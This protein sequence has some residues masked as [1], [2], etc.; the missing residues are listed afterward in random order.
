MRRL[1]PLSLFL[2]PLASSCGRAPQP[3]GVIRVAQETDPSTLDP[4]RSYDS[5]SIIYTR[6]LYRGLVDYGFDA[7]I[8]DE[9]AQNHTISPDGK[10]YRFQLRPDVRWWDG[11][12][13]EAEDFRYSIE[14]ALD[15][16]TASDGSSFF[17]DIVGAQEWVNSLKTKN[18]LRH[19]KGLEVPSPRELVIH[20]SKPDSTFLARLTLPFAYAVPHDYVEGLRKQYGGGR[21]L[22]DALSEHPMGC[23]PFKFVEWVHDSSLRLEKNPNYFRPDLPKANV[24]QLQ[25]GIG[26]TL[27]TMLFEQGALDTLSITDAFPADFLR[28]K[29][30]PKWKAFIDDAPLMDIRYMAMNTE[31]EPFKD[32]RVR[33]AVSYAINYDRIVALRTGRATKARGALPEGVE[34]YDPKLFTY[35]YDPAKAKQLLKE[36][37]FKPSGPLPLIYSTSEQWYAKAAQSIQQDLATVGIQVQ[38][39]GMPYGDLKAIAAR[40]GPSGGRFVIQGW[41][42]DFPDPSNYLDPLFN[43]RSIADNGSLNRSFYSNPKVNE[44]LDSGLQTP[45]GPTRWKKYQEAQRIIVNDAPVVFLNNTRRYVIRQPRV[46]GF[47]LHPE[48]NA[49]YEYLTVD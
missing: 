20:L 19:V 21:V 2:L 8:H 14:R 16:D 43:K 1:L 34:S 15:P 44:L 17:G 31:V 37:N 10:T 3:A 12:P 49:T 18:P 23:G 22:S 48:W 5:T 47:Q 45:N 28:L 26:A 41:S 32:R 38:I 46:Q 29:N 11:K 24:L 27:Q 39:K 33:Q 35:P 4:A 9:V 30:A 36:A 40:R 7:K 25:I 13:V 42:Q 6:L